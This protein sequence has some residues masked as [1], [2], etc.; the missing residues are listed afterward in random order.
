MNVLFDVWA[1]HGLEAKYSPEEEV[2]F[3]A[4]YNYI[5]DR[6]VFMWDEIEAEEKDESNQKAVMVYLL[7]QPMKI[8][9]IGYSEKL[10]EKIVGCFNE[11]D[12][13]LLWESVAEALRRFLN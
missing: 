9:P 7:E 4:I 8:Q 12:A 5:Y 1:K 11:K 6:I 13:D 3:E 2:A 10:H